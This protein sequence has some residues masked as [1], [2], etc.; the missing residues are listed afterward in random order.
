MMFSMCASGRSLIT[1]MPSL[2]A[3]S[4]QIGFMELTLVTGY[5]SPRSCSGGLGI[6]TLMVAHCRLAWSIAGK[7][8]ATF[9]SAHS[10]FVF[11]MHLVREWFKLDELRPLRSFWECLGKPGLS[12]CLPDA[13]TCPQMPPE[14]FRMPPRCLPDVGLGKMSSTK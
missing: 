10:L 7:S 5:S 6:G 13:F 4:S 12:R 11:Q 14:A 1:T 9:K 3:T 8:E 2:D